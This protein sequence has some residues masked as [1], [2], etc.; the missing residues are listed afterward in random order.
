MKNNP[1]RFLWVSLICLALLCVAVFMWLTSVMARKSDQTLTQVAN[2]Y[3]E[4]I[5]AQLKR[6]FDSLAE[7]QLAQVE[8]ITLAVPPGSIRTMDEAS[9]QTLA[10]SGRSRDF[11]YLALYNTEGQADIIYG[12]PVVIREEDAFLRSL[13]QA[14]PKIVL[15]DTDD[16]QGMLL[17]GVSVGYP[18]SEGY[19]MRDG[20]QCTALLA[21]VPIEYINR[22]LSLDINDTLV[23]SHIIETNGCFV[24]KNSNVDADNYYDWLLEGCEFDGQS[25]D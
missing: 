8:G 25:P 13:N 14:E 19:P 12:E 18:V 24:V 6:H 4:E 20:S 9:V 7:V 11:S 15:A 2:I 17:F 21:G 23:Y 3:M 16:G 1:L 10:A 22:S 5:N